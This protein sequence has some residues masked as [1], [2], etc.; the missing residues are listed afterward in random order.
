MSGMTTDGIF[1]VESARA[2]CKANDYVTLVPFG[3]VHYDSPAFAEDVWKD[4]KEAT[5]HY[6]NPIF[7]GMGDYMDSFSTSERRIVYSRD[8]HD[9]T[10]IRQEA[11]TRKRIEEFA[12]QISFMRGRLIGL[13]GGNHYPV[14]GGD[15]SGDQYLASLLGTKYLGVCSAIRLSM[16]DAAGGRA[17]VDIFAHHGRG[18][19]QTP[20]GKFSAVDKLRNICVADIFLSGHDHSRGCIPCGDRLYLDS[21]SQRG[22][23]I[24]SRAQWIGRTGSFLKSYMPGTSSY[25]VDRAL[26]PSSLGWISFRLKLRRNRANKEDRLSVEIRADQ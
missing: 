17:T 26:S 14:L 19:G 15:M 22:L 20:G 1:S 9:S 8:L 4:F 25:V 7:L 24:L 11:E 6:H 13:L 2:H 23:R 3:D 12:E 10:L 16:G 5:S 18:A 21:N